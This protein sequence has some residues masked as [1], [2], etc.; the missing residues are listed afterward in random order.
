[1]S[2]TAIKITNL[3]KSYPVDDS[4]RTSR[5]RNF[6]F[7]KRKTENFYALKDINLEIRKG[8]LIGIIGPNGAGKSTLLKIIAEVSPPTEGMVELEGK[9]ASILEIGI[10]FQ[11]ELS[12]YENIFLAGNLYGLKKSVIAEKTESIIEMFGFPDFIHTPVKYYSSGMY[13]R[14]A[15]SLIRYIE[16]D[17]YLFDEI[18]SVGDAQFQIRA[19][20]EIEKLKNKGKTICIVTHTPLSI[21]KISDTFIFLQ[22]GKISKQG[23]PNL[24]L[25]DI[26]KDN[27]RLD[28]E[29][30]IQSSLGLESSQITQKKAVTN[31]N[32]LPFDITNISLSNIDSKSEMLVPD[33]NLVISISV[34]Y[35]S[36]ED[37]FLA[38]ILKTTQNAI[39]FSRPIL[40]EKSIV[41]TKKQ[42]NIT[43]NK[44]TLNCFTYIID[45]QILNK[46]LRTEVSFYNLITF[47]LNQEEI[48][49][50]IIAESLGL[51]NIPVEVK[52]IEFGK[53][54]EE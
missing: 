38:F 7:L 36:E 14:L 40:M 31:N 27:V 23:K 15:F 13:M 53:N 52:I 47:S 18:F 25:E 39:L 35:C 22:N 33:K 26:H 49:D 44:N 32:S 1:M 2:S 45:I 30:L 20:S 37:I 3:G 28:K 17:I 24:V 21:L 16:A 34:E 9:V 42:I 6:S 4:D 43:I 48:K 54:N 51:V 29:I 46:S 11:P 5:F 8:E 10:G 50:T 41:K 19:L 12:G